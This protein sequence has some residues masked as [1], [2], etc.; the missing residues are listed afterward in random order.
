[1]NETEAKQLLFEQL[2][3]TQ[4]IRYKTPKDNKYVDTQIVCTEPSLD[5]YFKNLYN[6][7]HKADYSTFFEECMLITYEAINKFS[8]LDQ[9]SYEGVI[10]KTDK[11][12]RNRLLSYIK[13]TVKYEIIKK[14][15]PNLRYTTKTDSEGNVRHIAIKIEE[16]SLDDTALRNPEGEE[17][18]IGDN[19][20]EESNY[21]HNF[22][23]YKHNHY[24]TWFNENKQRVLTKSQLALLETLK[25]DPMETP[26][27]E[28][29]RKLQRIAKRI[30]KAYKEEFPDGGKT[31]L[32]I[33]RDDELKIWE[34]VAIMIQAN[35][36]E[37]LIDITEWL[38]QNQDE[39]VVMDLLDKFS[40][41][42]EARVINRYLQGKE[43]GHI[44]SK[45]L[46]PLMSFIIK[47]IKHL[48]IP[49]IQP[50]LPTAVP[51]AKPAIDLNPNSPS[52]TIIFTLDTYGNHIR[53]E[54]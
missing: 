15:N 30:D 31:I 52:A 16:L 33:E 10:D 35:E 17:V 41:G 46:Y 43:E 26:K 49:N 45:V 3:E 13:T 22:K 21:F 11:L 23:D 14:V 7:Y 5:Y 53:M 27:G 36:D 32:D 50:S 47:R 39:P 18:A 24:I 34:D 6:K 20:T 28:D 51:E 37:M 9:G 54:D 29:R 8:F 4:V 48:K 19:L 1:M 38:Q 40:T 42:Q 25:E 12:N 44:P 2:F